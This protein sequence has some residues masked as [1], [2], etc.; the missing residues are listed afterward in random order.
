MN[1]VLFNNTLNQNNMSKR[2]IIR[3]AIIKFF[4]R[5]AKT[6]KT[7]DILEYV[8]KKLDGEFSLD[9]TI[10]REMRQLR[11]DGLI[12]YAVPCIKKMVHVKK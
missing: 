1:I 4:E 8:R 3:Q 7:V 5:K 12:D 6:F 2:K 9:G 10:L 11:S